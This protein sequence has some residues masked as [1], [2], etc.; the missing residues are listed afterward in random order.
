M[1]DSSFEV[2]LREILAGYSLPGKLL[3]IGSTT[4]TS[5]LKNAEGDVMLAEGNVVPS[6]GGADYAKECLFIKNDALTGVRGLYSNRGT[7]AACSF[8]K[9]GEISVGD[10]ILAAGKIIYGVGGVGSQKT[11]SVNNTTPTALPVASASR[12][13]LFE[14]PAAK[15]VAVHA[16]VAESAVNAFPGPFTNPV[17]P[18]SIQCDFAAGWEGGD[19]TVDGT[20]QFDAVISEVFADNPG[21][22][23]EG[24]KIFKTVTAVSKELTAGA[25]DTVTLQTGPKIGIIGTLA[26][27]VG[28]LFCNLVAEAVVLDLTYDAF[29]PTTDPDGINDYTLVVN[30]EHTH[31]QPAH[32]HGLTY[33]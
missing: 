28:L 14:N 8:K 27:A 10:I 12:V 31:A 13:I 32:N 30:L 16:A 22:V 23:V 1:A 4:F 6:D 20:D 19:V 21:A 29:T 33:T 11:I 15:A 18:R 9:L 17:I 25:A 26:D 24:L 7:K 5:Y 2:R 3:T